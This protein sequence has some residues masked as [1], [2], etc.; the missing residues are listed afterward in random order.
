MRE[1]AIKHLFTFVKHTN[2]MLQLLD[3]EKNNPSIT[4]GEL[5]KKFQQLYKINPSNRDFFF[6]NQHQFLTSLLAYLCLPTETYYDKLP[7]TQIINLHGRWG[8]TDIHQNISLKQFTKRLRNAVSHGHVE[9]TPDLIFEFVDRKFKIKLNHVNLYKFCQALD[10]WC[11]TGDES[12][13]GLVA[14]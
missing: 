6:Y 8:L 9:I 13:A 10:Y 2:G 7:E 1:N 5:H 4:L 12:L 14:A 11:L 3:A